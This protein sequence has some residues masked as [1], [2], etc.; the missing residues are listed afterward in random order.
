MVQIIIWNKVE[1]IVK[2]NYYV[3]FVVYFLILIEKKDKY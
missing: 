2:H 1:L 3:C